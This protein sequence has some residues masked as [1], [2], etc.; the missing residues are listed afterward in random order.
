MLVPHRRENAELGEARFA[1]DELLKARVFVRLEAVLGDQFGGDGGLVGFHRQSARF[2]PL[3][4][5]E[6]GKSRRELR[7]PQAL[8]LATSFRR[9]QSTRPVPAGHIW[10]RA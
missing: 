1:A 6:R 3:S 7:D 9:A 10:G 5:M 2:T 4:H 8:S